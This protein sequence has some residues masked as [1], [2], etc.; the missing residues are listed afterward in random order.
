MLV[1]INFINPGYSDVLLKTPTGHMLIYLGL[2]LLVVGALVI[3]QIVNGI[4]V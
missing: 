1:V 2:F 4:E 3:R